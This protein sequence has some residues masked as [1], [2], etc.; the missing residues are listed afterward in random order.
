MEF[1][2]IL[3]SIPF[4]SEA[5]LKQLKNVLKIRIAGKFVYK[6]KL[7]DTNVI[8]MNTGIGKVN[9]AHSATALLENFRIRYVVN[10]GAGGAYPGSGL[11][12]GD[13]AIATKE[14]YGDEGVITPKGWKDIKEIGIPFV[15]AGKK[16]YFNE[17]PMDMELIKKTVKRLI[18]HRPEP[19]GSGH[20]VSRIA[21]IAS[22]NFITVSSASGTFKKASELERRFNA[23]CENMEGAAIAHVCTIYGIH[24]LEVRG[25]SNI[26]GVRDKRKWD[27]KLAS[28][29]CQKAVLEIIKTI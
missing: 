27:L 1:L 21:H 7:S 15:R 26:A 17:F 18:A 28:G 8:L 29:N 20:N 3:A 14:I 25:I 5:I 12:I 13:I 6:G 24:M 19:H 10:I 11:D 22:G 4:E 23:I 9:A 2:A 16:K